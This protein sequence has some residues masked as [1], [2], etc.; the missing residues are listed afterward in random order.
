[1]F[2]KIGQIGKKNEKLIIKDDA[3]IMQNGKADGNIIMDGNNLIF[4][5]GEFESSELVTLE[6]QKKKKRIHFSK[7]SFK[8]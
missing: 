4:N 5:E 6:R 8:T 2:I 3:L 7:L 1:M